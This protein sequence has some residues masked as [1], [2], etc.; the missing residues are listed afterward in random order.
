MIF[1]PYYQHIMLFKDLEMNSFPIYILYIDHLIIY[2]NQL[3]K[4]YLVFL[5]FPFYHDIKY[6]ET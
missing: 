1:L 3:Y 2:P 5:I 6:M 4:N